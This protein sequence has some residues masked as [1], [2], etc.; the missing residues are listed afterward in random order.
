MKK[1]LL[2][3][4]L[5]SA[6]TFS[7][8]QT[9]NEDLVYPA[10]IQVK[11]GIILAGIKEGS[12]PSLELTLYDK[13]LTVIK[14]SSKALGAGCTAFAITQCG[15]EEYTATAVL[16]TGRVTFIFNDN[17]EE[18]YFKVLPPISF[19]EV[20]QAQ[21][22]WKKQDKENYFKVP[23]LLQGYLNI[24][25]EYISNDWLE[26]AYKGKASKDE[27]TGIAVQTLVK[28][29]GEPA[30]R[31]F[32]PKNETRDTYKAVWET[33]LDL[34]KISQASFIHIDEQVA[35]ARILDVTESDAGQEYVY[36]F[37]S[38]TGTILYKTAI[39]TNDPAELFHFSSGFYDASAKRLILSGNL[40]NPSDKKERMQAMAIM[41]Y[42]KTNLLSFQKIN[43]PDYSS[44]KEPSAYN[45]KDAFAK[46]LRIG[47][48]ADGSY[49]ID[50]ENQSKRAPLEIVQVGAA[51]VG[52][53]FYAPIGYSRHLLDA[54]FKFISSAFISLEDFY[55]APRRH[56]YNASADGEKILL[57]N[58]H[59]KKRSTEIVSFAGGRESFKE[60]YS[61]SFDP[62]AA[63]LLDYC[64]QFLMD[65]N[66]VIVFY[67]PQ[68][69]R[70][71]KLEV[72][73]L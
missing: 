55:D 43:F 65:S 50:C 16:E 28:Y 42:D 69:A 18:K 2:I 57:S 22:A 36:C 38:K 48:L 60:L 35:I 3:I 40:S 41:A 7:K 32:S 25:K 6:F 68:N 44:L 23:G 61:F 33:F 47:K 30:V 26:I 20:M 14:K 49:Y 58:T 17:L 62:E 10:V 45:F 67:T 27:T 34:K 73:K 11:N 5:L 51:Q 12:V 21:K 70:G 4:L 71:C 64:H 72:I 8:A 56:F 1:N 46:T 31:R 13:A 15:E 59:N 66:T 37:D 19:S 54:N 9:I 24:P 63:K 39:K 52:L 29:T 53:P